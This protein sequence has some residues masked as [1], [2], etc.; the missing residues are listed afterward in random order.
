MITQDN[1]LPASVSNFEKLDTPGLDQNLSFVPIEQL[2]AQLQSS[3]NGLS[4]TIARKKV[5]EQ[6]GS[7]KTESRLPAFASSQKPSRPAVIKMKNMIDA[8]D[9]CPNMAESITATANSRTSGLLNRRIFRSKP[10]KLLLITGL[11]AL[12]FTL[13]LPLSPFAYVFFFP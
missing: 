11:I 10:G 8:S 3:Q 7:C 13:Y 12:A 9:D 6:A 5:G 4:E 2:Y 1:L